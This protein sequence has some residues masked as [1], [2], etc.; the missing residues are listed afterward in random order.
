VG[1]R[2]AIWRERDKG[3]DRRRIAG[4]RAPINR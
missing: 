3:L 2:C 4:P 1:H